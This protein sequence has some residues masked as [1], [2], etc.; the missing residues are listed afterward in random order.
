MMA[1]SILTELQLTHFKLSIKMYNANQNVTV[2]EILFGTELQLTHFKLLIKMYNA[3]QN[4]T[5]AE[6]LFGIIDDGSK[7]IYVANRK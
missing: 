1:K 3:N 6:I 2:A 7:L 4:V 5:V